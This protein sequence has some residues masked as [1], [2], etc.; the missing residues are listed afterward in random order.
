MAW[1]WAHFQQ[2]NCSFKL[3]YGQVYV[4]FSVECF[5]IAFPDLHLFK[6]ICCSLFL[7]SVISR[8]R[9]VPVN[10]SSECKQ[11][12]KVINVCFAVFYSTGAGWMIVYLWLWAPSTR[13]MWSNMKGSFLVWR[14]ASRGANPDEPPP[15]EDEQVRLHDMCAG[16]DS[17]R[18][19][20]YLVMSIY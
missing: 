3:Q 13:T 5:R 17:L 16:D 9:L 10:S 12:Q 14:R 2:M 7:R 11:T 6:M 19:S 4:S 20:S 1:G 18:D 15:E 8:S